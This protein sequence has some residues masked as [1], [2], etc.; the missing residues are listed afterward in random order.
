MRK[1]I[2]THFYNEEY[3]LPWWLNHHKQHFDH[4][5]LINY[6]STDRSVEI[7]K[8]ICPGWTIIDSRNLQ[9]DAKLADEEV[10]DIENTIPGWK[11]CLNITEFLIGD[12]S[13]L[14]TPGVKEFIIPCCVMVDTNTTDIP[15]KDKSLI[16]QKTSGIHYNEGGTNIRRPRLIHNKNYY[17]YPLG[18]HFDKSHTTDKLVVLWYGWSPFNTEVIKRKLQIQTRIPASDI[19]RGF[20]REH[21]VNEDNL[22]DTHQRLSILSRDLSKVLNLPSF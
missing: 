6:A 4:G 10:S 7:I 21:I 1:T 17:M 15:V 19:A 8:E 9:F 16:E 3:L 20:G 5:V 11:I 2:I 18:R 12:Y 22:L 14:E 13:I